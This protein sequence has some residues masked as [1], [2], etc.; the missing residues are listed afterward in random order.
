MKICEVAIIFGVISVEQGV[1]LQ[2]SVWSAS[3]TAV[4]GDWK[5]YRAHSVCISISILGSNLFNPEPVSCKQILCLFFR[6][7]QI[8]M[9]STSCGQD[10]TS[11][12]TYS[13]AFKI[14]REST[15]FPGITEHSSVRVYCHCFLCYK[16]HHW[17]ILSPSVLAVCLLAS[18]AKRIYFGAVPLWNMKWIILSGRGRSPAVAYACTVYLYF[19]VKV[20]F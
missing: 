1:F 14:S 2:V 18:S 17:T 3:D 9:T 4:D 15:T 19:C 12:L 20:V 11:S 13:V 7:T 16:Y 10:R 6:F 5:L 8:V